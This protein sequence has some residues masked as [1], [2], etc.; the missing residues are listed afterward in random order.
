MQ[1]SWVVIFGVLDRSQHSSVSDEQHTLQTQKSEPAV[2]QKTAKLRFVSSV[3]LRHSSGETSTTPLSPGSPAEE[4]TGEVNTNRPR[5]QRS[6]AQSRKTFRLRR[7]RKNRIEV[8]HNCD[9][10]FSWSKPGFLLVDSPYQTGSRRASFR[11]TSK[12]SSNISA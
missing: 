12:F 8:C 5:L 6:K 4:S 3:E 11:T 7:S 1:Q 9:C 10:P 2:H